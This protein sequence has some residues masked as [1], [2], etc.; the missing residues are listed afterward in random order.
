MSKS[1][2]S[3]N[4]FTLNHVIPCLHMI[5]RLL[6]PNS[7]A[8]VTNEAVCKD[9]K[10]AM[11]DYSK[12]K[13]KDEQIVHRLLIATALDPSHYRKKHVLENLETFGWKPV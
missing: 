12:T 4:M 6:G 8:K 9:F 5:N 2:Q 3:E 7:E 10:K 11:E 1:I 13:Y